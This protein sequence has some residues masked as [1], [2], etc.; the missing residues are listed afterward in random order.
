MIKITL[1]G[2]IDEALAMC[3]QEIVTKSARR[4][5]SRTLDSTKSY[6]S[7]LINKETKIKANMIRRV[8][9]LKKPKGSSAPTYEGEMSAKQGD[10]VPLSGSPY[11]IGYVVKQQ[12]NA[13]KS[14][15]FRRYQQIRV[16]LF[17]HSGYTLMPGAFLTRFK[18]NGGNHL[19]IAIRR[20]RNGKRLPVRETLTNLP[21]VATWLIKHKDDLTTY[22]DE[23]TVKEFDWALKY[24]SDKPKNK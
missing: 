22:A 3:S 23:L 15:G 6:A 18:T 5:I 17:G 21:D 20:T 14:L 2:R 12:K 9:I 1:T 10:F 13:V 7:R 19:A 16:K 11:R 24:Y 4:A 8:I